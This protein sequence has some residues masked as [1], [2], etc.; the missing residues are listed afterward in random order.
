MQCKFLATWRLPHAHLATQYRTI[1]ALLGRLLSLLVV[2]REDSKESN[3]F[4][5][6]IQSILPD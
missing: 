3:L 4:L 2:G 6:F 1:A 5:C